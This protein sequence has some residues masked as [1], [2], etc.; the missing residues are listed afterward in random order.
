LQRPAGGCIC[1]YAA[2]PQDGSESDD[3]FVK[4]I[5]QN[6]TFFHFFLPIK[7]KKTFVSGLFLFFTF[8][9]IIW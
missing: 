5:I 7:I 2:D 3:N 8:P 1:I 6:I 9:L 4:I